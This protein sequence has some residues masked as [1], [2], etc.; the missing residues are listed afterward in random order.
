[1]KKSPEKCVIT[2]ILHLYLQRD[3]KIN[4]LNR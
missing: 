1:M 2:K 3:Y 4:T